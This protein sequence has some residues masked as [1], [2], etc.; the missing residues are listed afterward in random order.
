MLIG[1][2]DEKGVHRGELPLLTEYPK[3]EQVSFLHRNTGCRKFAHYSQ[4]YH[5]PLSASS[6]GTNNK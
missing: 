3:A 5:V 2:Q 4:P 1:A 6:C